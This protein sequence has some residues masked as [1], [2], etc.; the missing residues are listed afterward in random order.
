MVK[1]NFFSRVWR[2]KSDPIIELPDSLEVSA[3]D[4][5]PGGREF[6]PRLEH[7]RNSHF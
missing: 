2:M 5:D 3:F 6:K 7:N 1:K 4:C